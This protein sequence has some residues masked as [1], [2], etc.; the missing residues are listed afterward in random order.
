M[1]KRLSFDGVFADLSTLSVDYEDKSENFNPNIQRGRANA[2]TSQKSLNI[3]NKYFLG[4]L[5]PRTWNID[6]PV[7]LSRNYSLGIPRFRANSDLLRESI[8]ADSTRMRERNESL[9]YAADFA[10]SMK[11]PPKNFFLLNTL[12]RTSISGR[13]ESAERNQPT[14]RDSTFTIRGTYNYNLGFPSD[15]VSFRLFK[16]Y[17]LGWFPTWNNSITYN[18][19]NPAA[20]TGSGGWWMDNTSAIGSRG[21]SVAHRAPYYGFQHQLGAY[22]R[23][24]FH[25]PP[26][27]QARF[28]AKSDVEGYQSGQTH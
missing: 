23:Y 4:R 8:D 16:N 3:N 12:Y 19:I 5:F 7:T 10:Y 2:F 28:E 24:Q 9:T 18:N 14:S 21:R 15:K 6:M 22:Q 11:N 20:K 26:Q 27:Y 17:R 13:I 25:R 1:A